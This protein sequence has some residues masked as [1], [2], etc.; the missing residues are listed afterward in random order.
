MKVLL[1]NG[2]PNIKGCTYTAL[3]EVAG[4]L[5]ASGLET[6][7]LWLGNKPVR[8]CIACKACYKLNCEC[9]FKDDIVSELIQKAKVADG[10][11]FGSPVYFSHPSGV[12]QS[13][14]N[15]AFYAASA[16]FRQKPGMA[17]VSARRGG[18]TASFDVLNKYFTIAAMP[19]VSSTYWNMVHG[20]TP[21]EVRQDLEGLQTMRNG[22]KNMAWLLE[23]I[24]AA[25]QGGISAPKLDF[26]NRTNFIRL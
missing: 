2:S 22:A 9:V 25:R 4:E 23:C 7:I 15:R 12:I 14:L 8:D 16:M 17:V 5:Q 19:V 20:N 3:Q 11:V 13:V 18:T 10:F 21:E 26:S 1:I 24:E 6:E